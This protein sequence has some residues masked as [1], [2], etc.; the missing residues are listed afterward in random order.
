MRCV[1]WKPCL[2]LLSIQGNGRN[3]W[4][5]RGR[6]SD[7]RVVCKQVRNKRKG[8]SWRKQVNSQNVTIETSVYSCVACV[9]SNANQALCRSSLMPS[10][11]FFGAAGCSIIPQGLSWPGSLFSTQTVHS[12]CICGY[13]RASQ[14]C[15]QKLW[16]N[17]RQFALAR[18]K[19]IFC[20][21]ECESGWRYVM[22]N[23]ITYFVGH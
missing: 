7:A 10:L 1:G 14:L 16:Q 21:P 11:P 15:P 19:F 20:V 8:R 23:H 22:L 5:L 17:S 9:A 4:L 2:S 18:V 6:V 13:G 3:A 12:I